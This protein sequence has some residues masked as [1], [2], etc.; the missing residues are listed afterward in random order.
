MT[1]PSVLAI[2]GGTPVRT[3]RLPLSAAFS[4]ADCDDVIRACAKVFEHAGAR[5]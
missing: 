4:D 5:P 3:V 1:S 2:D